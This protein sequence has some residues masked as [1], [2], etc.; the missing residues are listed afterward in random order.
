[1]NLWSRVASRVL[2]RIADIHA[3]SF[4]E[5][6]RRLQRVDWQRWIARG[7]P[8]R[9]SVTCRKSR[10]YHSDAVAERVSSVLGT[11]LGLSAVAAP[12]DEGLDPTQVPPQLL[13]VRF[14]RDRCTISLD[15][16]G[17]LLHQRGYRGAA[18]RAPLRETLAAAV[19]MALPWSGDVPLVDPMCG[20]GTIAIEAALMARRIAPGI[21]RAFAFERWPDFERDLWQAARD[22]AGAS[23]VARDFAV[24]ILGSDRD[25]GAVTAARD[26]ARRAGVAADVEFERKT[27]S[28]IDVPGPAG[29]VLTNPPYGIRVGD[30][31]DLRDLY[32]RFGTVLRRRFGGWSLGVLSADR[33]LEGQLRIPLKER[34]ALSNGGIRV[35][36]MAGRIEGRLRD[37]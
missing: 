15:S 2:V 19:L 14:Y 17:Q 10:L 34:L 5:L 3:T 28:E 13:V 9:L 16:S 1:M 30:R 25:A 33:S 20:S 21:Q 23:A 24:R 18:G 37:S 4:P 12:D 11:I 32:A 8:T 6:D 31:D 36:L 7:L 29:L 22:A 27:V 26:N 35:R